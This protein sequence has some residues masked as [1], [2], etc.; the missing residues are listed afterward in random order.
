VERLLREE[1]S[2]G[3][4]GFVERLSPWRNLSEERFFDEKL[5]PE[6]TWLAH[7]KVDSFTSL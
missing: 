5:S 7:V 3:E 4:R 2:Q 1:N 6:R